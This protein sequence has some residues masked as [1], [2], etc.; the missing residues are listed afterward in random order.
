MEKAQTIKGIVGHVQT[1]RT[2][3]DRVPL[4]D[5][6]VRLASVRKQC[7]TLSSFSPQ[8]KAFMHWD[9]QSKTR[10]REIETP[11]RRDDTKRKPKH[12]AV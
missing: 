6:G 4:G 2:R 10:F 1:Q 7:S 9:E 5:K 12:L 3:E 11:N 8:G